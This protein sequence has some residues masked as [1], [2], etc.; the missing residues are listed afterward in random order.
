MNILFTNFHPGGGGG[1]TTYLKYLFNG[2]SDQNNELNLF[3][4]A[5]KSSKL[6]YELRKKF[7]SQVFDVDFPGKP[8]NFIQILSN[9]RVLAK[10]IRQKKI[11]VIHT[12]GT[13]DHKLVMICKWMFKFEFKII[14]TKHDSSKIKKHW[15]AKILY[16]KYTDHLIVVSNYQNEQLVNVNLA[17]KTSVI[18][19]G[20]DLNYFYPIKKSSKLLKKYQIS[21]GEIV[22]VSVAGTSLH[23]GWPL[24]VEALSRLE[25]SQIE[26]F[27]IFVAGNLPSEKI[28]EDYVKKFKIEKKVVFTGLLD[29]VRDLISIA[30]FGFVLST[31][32]ETISFACREMMA[33]GV[34]VLVSDYGG[35]PENINHGVDG[36]IVK[37]NSIED[38]EFFL[39]SLIS[40]EQSIFSKLAYQKAKNRFSMEIFIDKTIST[41]Y[42]LA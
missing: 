28:L 3:I 22:F 6:N 18:H 13:P 15:F 4:A 25:I 5:P 35:L 29:D 16:E 14:R 11:D 34:P 20:V 40:I 39:N 9:A 37:Q 2:I 23:K 26:K 38:I 30:D 21:D 12:N 1:H 36:W 17:S 24:L 42:N 41:Y 8:K 10:V 32:V 19:N 7:N 27:K 31:R 33:M